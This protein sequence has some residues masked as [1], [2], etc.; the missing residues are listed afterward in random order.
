MIP[1]PMTAVASGIEPR[2]SAMTALTLQECC[3]QSYPC[4]GRARC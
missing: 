1:E 4:T 2:P 3:E